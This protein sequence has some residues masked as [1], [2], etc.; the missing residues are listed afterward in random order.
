[1]T[2]QKDIHVN[3]VVGHRRN[4][5]VNDGLKRLF[6]LFAIHEFYALF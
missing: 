2:K 5:N 3:K 4:T 1:M 6:K